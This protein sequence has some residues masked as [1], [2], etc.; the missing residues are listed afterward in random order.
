MPTI[1]F[2]VAAL[3]SKLLWQL[4]SHL[5]TLQLL[6][7]TFS[8]WLSHR[9]TKAY[10]SCFAFKYM[11]NRMLASHV[12]A[13]YRVVCTVCVCPSGRQW[14]LVTFR[15][16]GLDVTSETL[17]RKSAFDSCWPLTAIVVLI[18]E[19]VALTYTLVIA[20]S[21]VSDHIISQPSKEGSINAYFF[22]ILMSPFVF[23]S[24]PHCVSLHP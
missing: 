3:S 4:A 11:G 24:L 12:T 5:A 1:K 22:V 15:L 23:V 8:L 9:T 10:P 21:N 7:I 14:V 19:N 18:K 13:H 6:H 17:F 2:K 20:T 16:K